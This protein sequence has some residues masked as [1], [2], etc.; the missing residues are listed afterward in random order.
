MKSL[1]VLVP[2]QTVAVEDE[3]GQADV[4]LGVL[5]VQAELLV[6]VPGRVTKISTLGTETIVVAVQ[7]LI[8]PA[9]RILF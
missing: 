2:L 4:V 9:P 7:H 5:L 6:E 8:S 1:P 3:D